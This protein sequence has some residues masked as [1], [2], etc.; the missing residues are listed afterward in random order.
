MRK[1]VAIFYLPGKEK[2]KKP[3]RIASLGN[4]LT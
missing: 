4:I 2:H 3:I 1:K